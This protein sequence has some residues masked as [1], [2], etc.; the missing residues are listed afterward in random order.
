MKRYYVTAIETDQAGKNH[1]LVVGKGGQFMSDLDA[2]GVA[3]QLLGQRRDPRVRDG[4]PMP[5][6][7]LM[8]VWETEVEPVSGQEPDA[9]AQW[10][11]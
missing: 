2:Q 7:I 11:E 1:A 9:I 8:Q 6:K 5:A 4:E 10:A 3:E